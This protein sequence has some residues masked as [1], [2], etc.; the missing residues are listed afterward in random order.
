MKDERGARGCDPSRAARRQRLRYRK[1]DAAKWGGLSNC[2]KLGRRIRAAGLRYCP[3]FLGAGVGL[4]ASA[5]LLA[6]V[7]GDGL[8][9]IDN[10]PNPLRTLTC[11]AA[12]VVRDGRMT[13]DETPGLGIVPDLAALREFRA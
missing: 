12:G 8:L 7:G 9:E 3:H 10:N 4:L 5:H 1:T 2:V 13:L 11:G 6:A